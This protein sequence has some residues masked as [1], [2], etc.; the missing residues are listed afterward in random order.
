LQIGIEQF[1]RN[2]NAIRGE[3]VS[4]TEYSNVDE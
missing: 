2:L 4:A 3:Y 1:F